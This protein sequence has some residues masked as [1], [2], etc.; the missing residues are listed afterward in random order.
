MRRTTGPSQRRDYPNALPLLGSLVLLSAALPL[1]PALL[2]Q[3]STPPPAVTFT[4]SRSGGLPSFWANRGHWTLGAQLGFAIENAVPLNISH[5]ALLIAQP[6][7]GFV[8]RDFDSRHFPVRRFEILNEG[9]LGNAVHPGGRL[10][11]YALSLRFDGKNHGHI[12]PFLDIGAGVLNTTLGSRVPELSGSTQFS[13]QAGLGIQ[14]FFN[15]QRAFVFEYRF[16]HM[17]NA[18]IELPN[19]GFNASMLSLGFRWL[20]R[21]RSARWKY[22]RGY[23]NP[24][25]YL[26]RVD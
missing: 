26:F 16:L 7:L 9:I 2:A 1:E 18:N 21:P 17:S 6:Q 5:I 12:V 19:R 15:P 10:R 11:G 25:R 13:P 24:L 4:K 23:R 8:V 22:S 3:S 14:Y 20:R